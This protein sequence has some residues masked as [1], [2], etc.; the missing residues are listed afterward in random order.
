[1][2]DSSDTIC[3]FLGN[4]N[5]I[6]Y[7][8]Y[9]IKIFLFYKI[10]GIIISW[11]SLFYATIK[12]HLISFVFFNVD[13]IFFADFVTYE[14]WIFIIGASVS[15]DPRLLLLLPI[16]LEIAL[17]SKFALIVQEEYVSAVLQ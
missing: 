4:K 12:N 17:Y 5:L 6:L 10:K 11:V 16:G 2:N 3:L 1:M 9:V 15:T 14:N 7:K 8:K 13:I